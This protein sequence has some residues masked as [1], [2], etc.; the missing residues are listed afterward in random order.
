MAARFFVFGA[1][2]VA[3]LVAVSLAACGPLR[4]SEPTAGPMKLDDPSLRRGRDLYDAHCYKCHT[5]GEGGM[6]PAL[7]DMP[8]PQFLIRFQTRHGLGAMPAFSEQEIGERE[9]QD[10]LNYIVA[11]RR[12]SNR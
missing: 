10:I 3:V 6:A 7:I 12:H 11:L 9:L 5:A 8:L 2:S 4:S 1:A